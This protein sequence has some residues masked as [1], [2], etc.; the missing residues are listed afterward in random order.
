M[1]YVTQDK[2]GLITGRYTSDI[3]GDNI[4]ANA[5]EVTE[6]VF[7][8]SIQMHR[9]ALVNNELLELPQ[10]A[11]TPEQLAQQAKESVYVLL[12][13]TAQ[14]YDYRDFA[15][16]VQFVNSAVWKAEADGLLAWQDNV[17]FKAYELLKAPITSVDDFLAQ[18]PKYVPSSGS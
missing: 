3:H 12:D 16:V 5:I 18:L 1:Y 17:W 11:P 15:E 4:P 13:Q 6:D 8:M 7:N 9:P 10:D 2:K 14:S